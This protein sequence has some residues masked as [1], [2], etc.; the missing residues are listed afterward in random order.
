MLRTKLASESWYTVGVRPAHVFTEEANEDKIALSKLIETNYNNRFEEIRQHWGVGIIGNKY[1]P[2]TSKLEKLR[3][4][5]L[6]QKTKL[7]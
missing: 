4:K 5:E 2:K 3:Q 1:Q 6:K 7:M